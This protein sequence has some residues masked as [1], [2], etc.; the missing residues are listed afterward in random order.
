[1]RVQEYLTEGEESPFA[2]WFEALNAPA[3][4]KVTTALIRLQQG[5]T[6]RVESVGGGGVGVQD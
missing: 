2:D 4:A 5:I 1:M 6:S 3:A